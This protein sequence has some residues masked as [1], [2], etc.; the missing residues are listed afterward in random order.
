MKFKS[1]HPRTLFLLAG[2]I[3]LSTSAAASAGNYGYASSPSAYGHSRTRFG[4]YNRRA[5][6]CR[7]WVPGH[8][9]ARPTQV[10]IPGTSRRVWCPPV[11]ET[12]FQICGTP[13]QFQVAAGYYRTDHTPGR[14]E[15]RSRRVWYPGRWNS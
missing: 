4:G 8:Y 9:E 10:W 1:K 5:P 14:Y 11:F 15:R 2:M 3:L 6:D 12:R 13:F 7:T